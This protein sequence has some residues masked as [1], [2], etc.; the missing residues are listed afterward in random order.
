MPEG[1]VQFQLEIFVNSGILE[2]E[3]NVHVQLNNKDLLQVQDGGVRLASGE[4]IKAILKRKAYNGTR[5][6]AVEL[7]LNRGEKQQMPESSR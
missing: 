3:I 5:L 7:Q 4:V 2:A 1:P 6:Y